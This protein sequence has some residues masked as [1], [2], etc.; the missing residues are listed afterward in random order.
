M[1]II[2][3]SIENSSLNKLTLVITFVG[4]SLSPRGEKK[5]K[6]RPLSLVSYC[7]TK[8]TSFLFCFGSVVYI[9]PYSFYRVLMVKVVL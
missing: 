2:N 4:P 7:T 3:C 6:T 9:Y 5:P 1:T 8:K